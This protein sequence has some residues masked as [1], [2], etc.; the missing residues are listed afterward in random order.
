MES[1]DEDIIIIKGKNELLLTAAMKGDMEAAR[2]LVE[3]G[4]DVNYQG[5]T[6][7]SFIKYAR[8]HNLLRLQN[9]I[10]FF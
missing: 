6:N 2:K 1:K 5:N 4:A 9:F 10:V 3:E 7:Q 8:F